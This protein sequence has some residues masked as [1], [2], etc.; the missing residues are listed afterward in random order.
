[1]TTPAGEVAWDD[2]ER[3]LGQREPLGALRDVVKNLLESGIDRDVVIERMEGWRRRLRSEGR[4]A[5]EDTVL[6]VM[7]LVVGF[8]G[9]DSRL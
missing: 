1:V 9:P 4:D 5:E 2:V 3:A 8:S 6:E 7:D